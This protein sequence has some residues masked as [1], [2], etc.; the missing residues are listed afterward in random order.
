MVKTEADNKVVGKVKIEAEE[1]YSLGSVEEGA[2]E[3]RFEAVEPEALNLRLLN[4]RLLS[5][6]STNTARFW[7]LVL[8]FYL[9]NILLSTLL[10]TRSIVMIS[11]SVVL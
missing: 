10:T 8:I 7:C 2:Q 9:N 5:L 4:L 11:R 1:L 6:L 3:G